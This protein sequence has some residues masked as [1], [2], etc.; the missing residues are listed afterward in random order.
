MSAAHESNEDRAES[1]E[2]SEEIEKM[3]YFTRP[4]EREWIIF[5]LGSGVPP[6]EA[7][8]QFLVV[9][10]YYNSERYGVYVKRVEVVRLRFHN[11]NR[12]PRKRNYHEIK[13]VRQLSKK[14]VHDISLFT[15]PAEQIVWLENLLLSGKEFT[16]SEERGILSDILK[17]AD[18]L[19]GDDVRRAL[20]SQ[21]TYGGATAEY[22]EKD[23]GMT[24]DERSEGEENVTS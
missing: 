17:L 21:S 6:K 23:Y 15:N 1:V 16:V 24:S 13:K 12:D 7:A 18:R 3:P 8:E 19:T 4:N 10:P 9:F 20:S 22:T 14:D 5:T 11:W 2:G